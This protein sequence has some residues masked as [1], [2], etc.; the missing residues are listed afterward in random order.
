MRLVKASAILAA[1]VTAAAFLACSDDVNDNPGRR[2]APGADNGAPVPG[3]DLPDEKFP[4]ELLDPY[5]G[6]PIDDYDNTTLSYGQLKSRIKAVFADDFIGGDTEKYIASKIALLGGADFVEHFGEARTIT[7]DYLLALDA[8]AKDS[9][10]RASAN[11]T[12]PFTGVDPA[13]DAP[14]GPAAVAGLLYDR[15]LF[16]Q[17]TDAEVTDATGLVSRLVPLSPSKTEAWAGL[18]E[19]LVRHPDSIFTL[20]PSVKTAAPADKERL[21]IIKLSLDFAGR[22]PTLT[23][24]TSLAGK[25]VAEKVDYFLKTP[26]FRDFYFHRTRVRT[27]SIGTAESDEPASLWT[28]LAVNG[29]PFQELLTA[30]YTVTANLAK[31]ARGPEHGKTGVLTMPGFIKTKAGLPHYNYAARV[32]TDFMG[33]LFEVPPDLVAMRVNATAASTV[34]PKSRCIACHGVLTPL[35]TQR[36]RWA[37]DG[38]YRTTDDKG[39]PIDDSDRGMVPDYPYKGQ[40]MEAFSTQAVKKERFLR[41]TFQSQFLFFLGRQMRYNLDERTVYLAMWRAAFDKNGDL[42]ETMKILANVPSYLGQ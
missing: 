33:Q 9:C 41:Q 36:L 37:D 30:D 6:P 4:P 10:A 38:T 26:D 25:S 17:P 2:N 12:G 27:E 40:G 34:D 23:E 14:G 28:Y 16:R 24:R 39:A 32:M 18:C 13:T 7:S 15:I 20:A 5:T 31:A 1:V 8:I 11:K 29:A 3:G 21:Q 35:A 42:R 19:A 22:I